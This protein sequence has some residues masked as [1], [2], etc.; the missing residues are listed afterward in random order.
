MG[1]YAEMQ[2]RSDMTRG[3]PVSNAPPGPRPKLVACPECGKEIRGQSGLMQHE[4]AKHGGSWNQWD[5]SVARENN[6]FEP[7][8]KQ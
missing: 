2:L 3:I 6:E 1:D 5:I 7:R 8:A 4:N